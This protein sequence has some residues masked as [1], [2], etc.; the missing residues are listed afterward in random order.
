[1]AGL[2]ET[3][4]AIKH[5][6]RL[7]DSSILRMPGIM[8]VATGLKKVKGKRTKDLS[9]I[10]Y[11]SKKLPL[12]RMP[13]FHAIPESLKMHGVEIPTDV[14][15]VGYYIPY[16]YTARER[17][18]PGG[19]S[20]GHLSVTAGTLG[21]LVCGPA[22]G[23]E[24]NK[25]MILSNNHVLAATNAG[26]KGDHI[27]QPAVADGGACH[28]DCIAELE[29]FV[30]INFTEG[31]VNYVDCAVA[32]PYS[33][34]DVSFEI[35]DIGYPNLT[36][37]HQVT[38]TDI[39]E[40][41]NVQKTG[42]TTGHTIGYVSAIDWKGTVLY[43][44]TPGYFEKQFVVESLNGT[45]VAAGGDSG[46]LVLT[47]DKKICGL[48]FAGPT[49]GEHYLA[50]HIGE[51][52]NRLNV[53]LCCAPTESTKRSDTKIYLDDIRRLRDHLRT[54]IKLRK[55]FDVYGKHSAKFLE[56]MMTN[57][58][59]MSMARGITESAGMMIRDRLR[60]LDGKDAEICQKM[61]DIVCK[62]RKQDA[63]LNADMRQARELIRKT[64]G[65]TLHEILDMLRE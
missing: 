29:R 57:P 12:N 24:E 45:K 8:A 16:N 15:E 32:L 61:I 13:Y 35:H 36:Q 14:I 65:R 21:G 33:S 53:R 30:P 2:K 6:R 55:Y 48:L 54:D 25:V 40:A 62:M 11:V 59:V 34:S 3:F 52:F 58:E 22:C 37:T 60:R 64:P 46:S 9:V 26:V 23:E 49:S 38:T 17:P 27:V 63:E 56:A 19:V 20:I 4:M 50:N 31:A 51:V 28:D 7:V 1:M 41:T 5:V 47:L 18:A 43:D 42:R 39:A 44:W 10:V